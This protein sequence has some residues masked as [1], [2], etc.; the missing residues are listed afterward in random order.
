MNS[1]EEK[2]QLLKIKIIGIGG[3][4]NNSIEKLQET[5][6]SQFVDLVVANTDKQVLDKSQ[7]TQK[8]ILGSKITYGLGAGANPDIGR[9]SA[10]AS[11]DA[12][13]E[14]LENVELLIITAGMGG[15][16]GT[17]AS[18]VIAQAAKEKG[19][20]TIAIVTSPFE[21]EGS[22]RNKNS[23]KGL[24]QLSKQVDSLVVVSNDK[25]LAKTP[26]V[27]FEDAF[28][29]SD[30]ILK[31]TIEIIADIILKPSHINLDFADVRSI[32]KD[33]R[34]TF[35]GFG[36]SYGK[37]RAIKAAEKS[38]SS[39]LLESSIEY[40]T[41]AV[42]NIVGSK[43]LSLSEVKLIINTIKQKSKNDINIIFGLRKDENMKNE[44]A[45]SII[46][47][48]SLNKSYNQL[49]FEDNDSHPLTSNQ[50][51]ENDS[52]KNDLL[53]NNTIEESV[54]FNFFQ[55][56]KVIKEH[57]L[58]QKNEEPNDDDDIPFFLK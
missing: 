34:E 16:T 37:D 20:L 52:K 3:C 50:S 21:I 38:L 9:E 58:Y 56:D 19:I 53:F 36:T 17:G 49:K 43:S 11:L 25:L 26:D 42:V 12:I 32:I 6:M 54:A 30:N 24:E 45:V 39:N 22:K 28:Q 33:S 55:D 31:K 40:C 13:K 4:G 7:I 41:D 44:V 10:L 51:F 2:N 1:L 48:R 29:F 47:T 57:H 35:I 15:G 18:P 23:K 46:A 27:P 8:I 14:Q 5:G